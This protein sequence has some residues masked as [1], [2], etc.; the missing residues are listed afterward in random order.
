VND[1]PTFCPDPAVTAAT[2]DESRLAA[3]IA[4]V[5]AELTYCTS[6]SR[7]SAMRDFQREHGSLAVRTRPAELEARRTAAEAKLAALTPELDAAVRRTH[8]AV[9]AAREIFDRDALPPALA[10][11]DAIRADAASLGERI[12]AVDA[13]FAAA[14]AAGF[15]HVGGELLG[16]GSWW[17]QLAA[18]SRTNNLAARHGAGR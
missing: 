3:A 16:Y 14:R 18:A 8:E 9:A 13:W 12:V 7:D 2:A 15:H 5:E 11:L 4:E 1:L 10:A 17:R 6:Q